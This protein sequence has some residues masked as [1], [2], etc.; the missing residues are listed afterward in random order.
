MDCRYVVIILDRICVLMAIL[1]SLQLFGTLQK[2]DDT[3][4]KIYL[5]T[6]IMSAKEECTPEG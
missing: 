1:R 3:Y 6:M 2:L 5:T 4:E